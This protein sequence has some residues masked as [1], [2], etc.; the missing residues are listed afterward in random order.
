MQKYYAECWKYKDKSDW[1]HAQHI[2]SLPGSQSWCSKPG[3]VPCVFQKSHNLGQWEEDSWEIYGKPT[4]DQERI[5]RVRM[6]RIT[7]NKC[8]SHPWYPQWFFLAL[9]E[10]FAYE[11]RSGL[12]FDSPRRPG[13]S[14]LASWAVTGH[15]RK[16]EVVATGWKHNPKWQ[17]QMERQKT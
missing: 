11:K 10:P 7:P 9:K 13:H 17:H 1:P 5:I 4:M 16:S 3:S 2:Y 8:Q 14:V 15:G 6:E 12:G